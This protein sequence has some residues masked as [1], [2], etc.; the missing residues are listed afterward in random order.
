MSDL[1]KPHG[2][3]SN[4]L[5]SVGETD[6]VFDCPSCHKTL[7]VDRLATG[8]TLTCPLCNQSLVAPETHRVVTLAEAP[9]TQKLLSKPAWEQELVSIESALKEIHHQRQEAGN[10]YKQYVSEANRQKL[11]IEK[12]DAK[13]RELEKRKMA[14][15]KGHLH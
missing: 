10:F 13:L 15:Q 14:V 1:Q 5:H 6:L 12:L 4:D 2:L 11:R 7:V 9:E 8:H 3:V